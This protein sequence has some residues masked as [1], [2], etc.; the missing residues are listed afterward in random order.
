MNSIKKQARIAGLLYLL[1]AIISPI[2]IMY[3]PGK[4]IVRGD[5]TATADNIRASESLFRIGIASELAG[6]LLMAC[7]VLQLFWLFKPVNE[8]LA[9]LML[10]WGALLSIPMTFLNTINELA[11]LVLVRG[12]DFLSAYTR[13]EMDSLSYLF[14]HLHGKTMQV[15]QIFWGLWLFPFGMLVI[16]SGFV[17]RFLGILLYI[18]GL[19]YCIDAVVTLLLPQHAEAVG[20]ITFVAFFGEL[21][22]ILWLL[23]WGA[24]EKPSHAPAL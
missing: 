14:L 9:W 13:A 16:R 23:I 21:P 7:V 3:V 4:L 6:A 1:V 22:I 19:G 24:K 5:A 12:P 2:G 11:A 8:K 10:I 17:P 20:R 18:A 15:A